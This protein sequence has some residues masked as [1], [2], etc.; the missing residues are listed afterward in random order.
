MRHIV[1]AIVA[2]SLLAQTAWGGRQL[3]CSDGAPCLLPI[4]MPASGSASC[5]LPNPCDPIP[6]VPLHCTLSDATQN[7]YAPPASIGGEIHKPVILSIAPV[8]V[9]VLPQQIRFTE[10]HDTPP[11]RSAL[12]T[13]VHAARAPP[14]VA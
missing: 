3:V 12:P 5:S 7:D 2:F 10:A 8:T 6:A 4:E 13:R 9:D 14:F 1:I 11:L